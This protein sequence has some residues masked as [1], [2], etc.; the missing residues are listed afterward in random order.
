VKK[1]DRTNVRA[2]YTV[3]CHLCITDFTVRPADVG[4]WDVFQSILEAHRETSPQCRAG[5]DDLQIIKIRRSR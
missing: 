1:R 5:R 2:R 4:G 3:R